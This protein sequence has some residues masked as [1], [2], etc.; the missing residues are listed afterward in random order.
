MSVNRKVEFRFFKDYFEGE[1]LEEKI[2]G[3]DLF[4][5]IEELHGFTYTKIK[6]DTDGI[7]FGVRTEQ[8]RELNN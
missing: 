4:P 5:D 7:T 2:L 6:R 1:V 3:K 8:V